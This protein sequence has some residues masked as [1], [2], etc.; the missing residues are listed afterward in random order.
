VLRLT[1]V[2]KLLALISFWALAGVPFAYWSGGV[3]STFIFDWS[4]MLVLFLLLANGLTNLKQVKTI[5]WVSVICGIIVSITAIL[6]Y[7][8]HGAVNAAGRLV[9]LVNGPY[10]GSNYFSVTIMLFLPYTLFEMVLNPRLSRRF[11]AF[12]GVSILGVANL[13]T[14]SRAG[15]LGMALVC[16]AFIWYLGKWGKSLVRIFILLA[17]LTPV[18]ILITPHGVWERFSTLLVDYDTQDMS[19][20]DPL[21]MAAGSQRERVQLIF[22]AL[23]LTIQNPIFG[24]GMGNFSTASAHTWSTGTG[25][26]WIQT[27]NTY[28]QFASELGVPGLLMYL[29]MLYLAF[30]GLLR[31]RRKLPRGDLGS[32]NYQLSMLRDATV[33]SLLGYALVSAFSNV[34]YQPYFFFVAGVAEAI[35]RVAARA[36]VSV[37]ARSVAAPPVQWDM[38]G[39]QA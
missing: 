30:K 25:R 19:V 13:L 34:G 22:K 15:I 36:T 33:L 7:A 31:P 23:G 4:K 24:V 38:P 10:S 16:M 39:V 21:R 8:I 27:H 9:A 6:N 11:L 32:R 28:L 2:T 3:L 12:A 29:I 26:D 18:F 17:L 37:P 35:Q 14:E 1:P 20:A 5:V